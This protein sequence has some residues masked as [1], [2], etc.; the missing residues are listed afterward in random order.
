[1][2][3]NYTKCEA[4]QPQAKTY[5]LADG[6]GLYLE[7]KPN[8]SKLWRLKYRYLG[9]EKKLAIGQY[10]RTSLAEA[11][12]RREEAKKQLEGGLDPSAL[13]QERKRQLMAEA[14][15]TF[16]KA[17]WK[18][19]EHNKGAW[20]EN[21]ARTVERRLETDILPVIGKRPLRELKPKDIL[22]MAKTIEDREA[23][24]IARRAVQY[25]SQIFRY[26]ILHDL[27]EYNPAPDIKGALKN[28]TKGHYAAFDYRELPAFLDKFRQNDARLF[29][30]TRQALELMMLTFVRTSELIKAR[31]EEIDLENATWMIPAA[32]M[33]MRRDHIVPLSRQA[34]A[35][36]KEV[37]KASGHRELV[38]P[39][40]KNPRKPMSNN[41]ILMA[42]G[43]MGYRGI[44][45]GHGFR[46]LAMSTIK[47]KL[48]Y[49]HEV[50]DRQLAH[51]HTR[52][53]DAAYDRAQFLEERIKMMQD[54]ADYLD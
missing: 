36:L 39:S 4:A 13:K 50:I 42:L 22:A 9:K 12:Q 34:V 37:K 16:E 29:P 33:K 1:M 46:A 7:I 21:H 20:S 32:R 28:Y 5:K 40:Q 23:Y 17:A 30:Q 52:Q 24:E 38:F 43:R 3:L 41:T 48:G 31:W 49:R 44:M 45:T 26:A 18:W 19:H 8:G 25:C 27:A 10:P 2:K 54:W 14:E 53:V 35:L 47:E 11:R 6:G 15:N 51:A